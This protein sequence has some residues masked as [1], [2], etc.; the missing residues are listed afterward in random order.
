LRNYTYFHWHSKFNENVVN[1]WQ[2]EQHFSTSDALR[3]RIN[4]KCISLR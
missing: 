4:E 1:R 3:R 2:L